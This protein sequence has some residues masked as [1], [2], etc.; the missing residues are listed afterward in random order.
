MNIIFVNILSECL[1]VQFVARHLGWYV[2]WISPVSAL[3]KV[4]LWWSGQNGKITLTERIDVKKTDNPCKI[5]LNSYG[6]ILGS[7]S[8]SFEVR[9]WEGF[10]W[11]I[12]PLRLQSSADSVTG[13]G[14]LLLQRSLCINNEIPVSWKHLCLMFT[15]VMIC[16]L[17]LCINSFNSSGACFVSIVQILAIVCG[18]HWPGYHSCSSG[19]INPNCR[20]T[21]VVTHCYHSTSDTN[22]VPWSEPPFVTICYSSVLISTQGCGVTWLFSSALAQTARVPSSCQQSGRAAVWLRSV[23]FGM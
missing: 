21:L 5:I 11:E 3:F 18:Q 22:S 7:R 8:P 17:C 1:L 12:H 10:Q 14:M 13:L 2:D 15:R 4:K 19:V 20:G 16:D 6:I 9:D 23:D